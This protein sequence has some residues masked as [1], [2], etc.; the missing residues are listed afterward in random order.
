MLRVC[1]CLGCNSPN[2][3]S[4]LSTGNYFMMGWAQHISPQKMLWLDMKGPWSRFLA[5][6]EHPKKR[7]LKV[8]KHGETCF[9][10]SITSEIQ[11]FHIIDETLSSLSR[12]SADVDL[13]QK[14][15]GR[16]S[17]WKRRSVQMLWGDETMRSKKN[18]CLRMGLSMEKIQESR[19][20]NG[21]I[22]GFRFWFSLKSIP[23]R[24]CFFTSDLWIVLNCHVTS[25]SACSFL[26]VNCS[27]LICPG[28]W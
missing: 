7:V 1:V 25:N 10:A 12:R 4:S 14:A 19:I 11:G 28:Q 16:L 20:F 2:S 21:N 26:F 9:A 6:F 27:N 18:W 17:S 5:P 3:N 15:P 22:Y 23:L 24:L 8:V 13:C